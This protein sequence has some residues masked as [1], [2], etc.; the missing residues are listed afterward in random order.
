MPHDEARALHALL[1][2]TPIAERQAA[3]LASIIEDHPGGAVGV[4]L[5]LVSVAT[6]L[7]RGIS[8]DGRRVI[9]ARMRDECTALT[10]ELQ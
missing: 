10:G 4:V 6:I 2:T 8:A 3:L 7:A 9:A 5:A 1:H